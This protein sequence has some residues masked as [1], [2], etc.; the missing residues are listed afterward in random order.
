MWASTTLQ[1]P[2]R[3]TP[4]EEKKMRVQMLLSIGRGRAGAIEYLKYIKRTVH[5]DTPQIGVRY[6][7]TFFLFLILTILAHRSFDSPREAFYARLL[8]SI[9]SKSF[10]TLHTP[11]R[12]QGM[13]GTSIS[14]AQALPQASALIGSQKAF[15]L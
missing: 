8:N 13:A 3:I 11:T 9:T 4:E 15:V 6:F 10:T 2:D 14:L 1:P 7:S 5:P 12:T